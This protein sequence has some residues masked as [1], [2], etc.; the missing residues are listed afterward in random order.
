MGEMRKI[1]RDSRCTVAEFG[2]R[3]LRAT[4]FWASGDKTGNERGMELISHQV[5][6]HIRNE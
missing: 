4:S 6:N 5:P 2:L 1:S 3:M